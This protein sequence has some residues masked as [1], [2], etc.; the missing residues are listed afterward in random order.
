MDRKWTPLW[1]KSV[2]SAVFKDDRLW[3][4]W[5]WMLMKMTHTKSFAQISTGSGEVVVPLEPGQLIIGRKSGAKALGWPQSSFRN[6][7]EKLSKPPFQCI[8]LNKD[9]HWTVVSVV[10]WDAYKLDGQ[11]EGQAKDKP[12]THSISKEEKTNGVFVKPTIEEVES[13]CRSLGYKMDAETFWHHHETRDWILGTGKKMK[14]WKS[15]VVTW[16]KNQ[17]KFGPKKPERNHDKYGY[18]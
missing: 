2:D 15:A 11:A 16:E 6:R 17:D 4:L 9:T 10:N 18:M 3:K 5:T 8:A 1:R 13:Y 14:K 7:V 12:R